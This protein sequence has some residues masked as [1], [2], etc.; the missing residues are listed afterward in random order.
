MLTFTLCLC[1]L[2]FYEAFIILVFLLE[3][4]IVLDITCYAS[5]SALLL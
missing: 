4:C 3:G 5:E 1:L 2:L